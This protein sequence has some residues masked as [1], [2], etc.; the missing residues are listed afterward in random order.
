MNK[1]FWVTV[2]LFTVLLAGGCD[3]TREVLGLT[4]SAPDEFAVYKRAP[5]SLPPDYGLKPPIPGATR[6]QAVEPR[7]QAEMAIREITGSRVE[8]PPP[9]SSPGLQALLAKT[10]AL[11]A[12]PG[13]RSSINR[14]TSILAEE[15]QTFTERIMFWGD[16]SVYG[17]VV[18]PAEETKRIQENLALGRPLN[19]GDVP[20]IKRKPKALLEDLF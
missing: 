20:V 1:A 11:N 3:S 14:E 16:A 10:G 6:R 17:S 12:D 7:G 2:S 19:Q 9:A 15:D 18:D 13:I 4:K 8:S 5:L